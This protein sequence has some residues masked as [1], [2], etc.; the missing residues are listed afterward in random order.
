M[1][2]SYYRLSAPCSVTTPPRP[3]PK[4]PGM[5]SIRCRTRMLFGLST[6][7][8]AACPFC[9]GGGQGKHGYLGRNSNTP[10]DGCKGGNC[11]AVNI[12]S[13]INDTRNRGYY[14]EHSWEHDKPGSFGDGNAFC[15][16]GVQAF[17]SDG[18]DF[19]A[20]CPSVDENG[21]NRDGGSAKGH[22]WLWYALGGVSDINSYCCPQIHK[23]SKI[24]A[25][26]KD[27]AGHLYVD[28]WSNDPHVCHWDGMSSGTW[29][30]TSTGKAL[31]STWTAPQCGNP[32]TMRVLVGRVPPVHPSSPTTPHRL[33]L[34]LLPVFPH[35][36]SPFLSCL[37]P[38]LN[39]LPAKMDERGAMQFVEYEAARR[40]VQLDTHG[41][42]RYG[43]RHYQWHIWVQLVPELA[44]MF[45]DYFDWSRWGITT[46]A[47]P[48]LE[49]GWVPVRVYSPE[50][51]EYIVVST[52]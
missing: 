28:T 24:P 5:T 17:A 12:Q 27:T 9:C 22:F 30:E 31:Y 6:A 4:N 43:H 42:A 32:T 23:S 47:H 41:I 44:S 29:K 48:W 10:K 33:P 45:P 14:I 11:Q 46:P 40:G 51:Q 34:L 37:F 36:T 50:T 49:K 7:A 25:C 19:F 18:S 26:N 52:G 8:G 16:R 38:P 2:F 21:K 15:N 13:V 3:K 20:C 39:T 35:G 1:E